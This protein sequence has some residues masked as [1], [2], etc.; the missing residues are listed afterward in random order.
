MEPVSPEAVF[1]ALSDAQRSSITGALS[2]AV[3]TLP[4]PWRSLDWS[5]PQYL[6]GF[7]SLLNPESARKTIPDTRDAGHPPALAFGVERVFNYQMSARGLARHQASTDERR[8]AALN[9]R[10]TGKLS[11][12][13]NVR[14]IPLSKVMLPALLEREFGYDLCRAP[15]LPWPLSP[16]AKLETAWLLCAPSG[17]SVV[18][19]SLLPNPRYVDICLAGARLGG[20]AFEMLFRRTSFLTDGRCLEEWLDDG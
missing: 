15:Y 11:D 9:A 7:G 5:A 3:E 2:R 17:S 4:Y 6:L 12:V 1:A 14:R 20:E 13:I 8:M 18:N 10:L 16:N 19:D